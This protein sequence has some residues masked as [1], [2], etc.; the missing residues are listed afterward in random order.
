M[1]NAG[2]PE[3]IYVG[4]LPLGTPTF[5]NVVG[6]GDRRGVAAVRVL[7]GPVGAFMAHEIGHGLDRKHAPCGDPSNPDPN[8]PDYPFFPGSIGEYG[9]DL[10]SLVVLDPN[11]RADFMS[12][13]SGNSQWVS[14]YTFIGLRDAMVRRWG[15]A[16]VA[17]QQIQRSPR[18][19]EHDVLFLRFKVHHDHVTVGRSLH[20]RAVPVR[21]PGEPTSVTVDLVGDAGVL[22]SHRCRLHDPRQHPDD[23]WL[24]F[25]ETIPWLPDV[26][27]IVFRRDGRVL[28]TEE[29]AAP[30]VAADLAQPT[31]DP[32]TGRLDL[33]VTA[34][35]ADRPVTYQVEFTHDDGETWRF[36]ADGAQTSW[37]V[38][39]R[40]LPGGERC[41]FR[42]LA[43]AGIR[44]A[45]VETDAFAI[46]VK[47]RRAY[48]LAPQPGQ[49]VPA[50]EL[51]DLRGGGL[52]L[53]QG[54]SDP[55]ETVW[56]SDLDGL[57]GR[58]H[59][60]ATHLTPGPHTLTL[61]APDGVGG[62]ATARV[63][64]VVAD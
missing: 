57:L 8:Y 50:G 45:E 34:A 56:M 22:I 24:S 52:G 64:I 51:V 15:P 47:P 7:T 54:L 1:R 3:G 9:V 41:R 18:Q 61:S 27:A 53:G 38:D 23:A 13:C 6:C 31:Y 58:G 16:G 4:L 43:V 63:A 25:A 30:L 46:P 60:V 48:I 14:P 55:L 26:R 44:T 39:P 11:N 62:V 42:V 32:T 2:D 5:A 36:V 28:H 49:R 29:L 37:V 59:E 12:Y 35:V 40:S 10:S 20:R 19:S 21:T 17:D 33:G